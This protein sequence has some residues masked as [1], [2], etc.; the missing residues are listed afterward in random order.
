LGDIA[1]PKLTGADPA[2]DHVYLYD[3][4]LGDFAG[5]KGRGGEGHEEP[6]RFRRE[7]RRPWSA[8]F[9]S[10]SRRMIRALWESL[11]AAD[12]VARRVRRRVPIDRSESLV[13]MPAR[14]A[15]LAENVLS[16]DVCWTPLDARNPRFYGVK[17]PR[18]LLRWT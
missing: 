15:G 3:E 14:I 10:N 9:S 17:R 11:P 5:A 2:E 1:G 6:S 7:R 8:S 13:A 18:I 16:M 12:S 4:L